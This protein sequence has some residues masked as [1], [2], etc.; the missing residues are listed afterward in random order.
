MSA[1][2][3]TRLELN[4]EVQG[5][6]LVSATGR[7]EIVPRSY[8][9]MGVAVVDRAEVDRT[10]LEAVVRH[11][12]D[13]HREQ[14][15]KDL[16]AVASKFSARGMFNSSMHAIAIGETVVNAAKGFASTTV[17]SIALACG[18]GAPA[19]VDIYERVCADARPEFNEILLARTKAIALQNPGLA[20]GDQSPDSKI[21]RAFEYHALKLRLGIAG[22]RALMAIGDTINISHSP[23]ANVKSDGAMSQ[24]GRDHLTQS[25]G[26]DAAALVAAIQAFRAGLDEA[27]DLSAGAK[28]ELD[29]AALALEREACD[30]RPD[31]GRLKRLAIGL[32]QRAEALALNLAGSVLGDYLQGVLGLLPK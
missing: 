17:E 23:G 28:A 18:S 12:L 2:S 31:I 11:A 13:E 8:D 3:E 15:L 24:V 9:F 22:G 20:Q 10:K 5:T 21:A 30:E 19:Y 4:V 29:D 26:V 6:A 32:A 1:N 14:L 7:A 25:A 16:L 27:T